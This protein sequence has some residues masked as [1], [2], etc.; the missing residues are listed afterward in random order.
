M[1]LSNVKVSLVKPEAKAYK[2]I[3]DEGIVLLV[4]SNGPNIGGG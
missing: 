4:Q 1:A 3:D 2:L